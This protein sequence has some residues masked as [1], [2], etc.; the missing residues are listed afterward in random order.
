[1]EAW[2]PNPVARP[3]TITSHHLSALISY[4]ITS[5]F[6]THIPSTRN[7]SHPSSSS[8]FHSLFNAAL[9]DYAD[10]TGTKLDDHP[11]AKQL[12]S[13][14]SVDSISSVL[15]E[16]ARRFTKSRGDDGRIM[17]C[18]KRAIHVLYTLSTSTALGEGIGQVCLRSLIAILY[19]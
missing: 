5:S 16:H 2:Q 4:K 7:M 8:S 13:C 14:D 19:P 11:V 6:I 1:M 15:Q 18:L 10:Q 9:Q 12:E 17:K 3:Y